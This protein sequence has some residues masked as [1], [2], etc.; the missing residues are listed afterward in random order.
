[1]PNSFL[2]HALQ[3]AMSVGRTRQF[4]TRYGKMEAPNYFGS[5]RP[6]SESHQGVY[7]APTILASEPFWR[8]CEDT[9]DS[10][11]QICTRNSLFAL[12]LKVCR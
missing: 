5:F 11:V 3:R 9:Q 1:M 10:A 4:P 2:P 6:A 8:R 7:G 12:R